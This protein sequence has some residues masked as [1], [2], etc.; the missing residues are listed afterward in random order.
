MRA[1]GSEEEMRNYFRQ[2]VEER[3][4]ELARGRESSENSPMANQAASSAPAK[5]GELAMQP[6]KDESITNTQHA[7]VDEGGIVKL[8]GDHLVVLRRGR[9]FTVAVGADLVIDAKG[10][11]ILP[12]FVNTHTHLAGALTKALT[13]D[14]PTYGGPFRIA[15][16]MHENIIKKDDILLPGMVHGVEMLKTGTTTINSRSSSPARAAGSI[17]VRSRTCSRSRKIRG[18]PAAMSGWTLPSSALTPPAASWRSTL[19]R[20]WRRIRF[21][22]LT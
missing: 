1:F 9:L 6:S 10:H 14:V 11:A 19:R 8:H 20:A 3:K 12:G 15:L 17:R 5:A 4:R 2:L 7:G 22:S 16:G 13:E 18:R 21:R